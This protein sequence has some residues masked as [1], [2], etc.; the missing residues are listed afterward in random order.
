LTSS[1]FWE[2][3][4]DN[5]KGVC[6]ELEI[7]DNPTNWEGFY[8]SMVKY[9]ELDRWDDF[10][11]E[12]LT[13]CDK[14]PSNY[15]DFRFD[16]IFCLHKRPDPTYIKEKEIRILGQKPQK[17]GWIFDALIQTDI[18]KRNIPVQ[19]LKLPIWTGNGYELSFQNEKQWLER[20]H[21]GFEFSIDD[22]SSFFKQSPKLK[23]SKVYVGQNFHHTGD[24]FD[25]FQ[26]VFRDY[27]YDNL[28]YE[29]DICHIDSV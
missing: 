29:I 4:G 27:T 14:H 17:H 7:V 1:K 13:H 12:I 2:E 5:G 11:S 8:L 28:G 18:G 23:I 24:D 22:F 6:I 19:Y 20:E 3:Y 25:T 26:K 10:I 21:H 9:G 15:Y 16:M